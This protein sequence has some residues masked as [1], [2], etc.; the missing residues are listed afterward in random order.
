ME[1]LRVKVGY[2]PLNKSAAVKNPDN[3]RAMS[4]NTE[5]RNINAYFIIWGEPDDY[6]TV[7]LKGS[8]T[9]SINERGPKSKASQKIV[10]LWCH[11]QRELI[12]RPW[13]IVE[14]DIGLR[15]QFKP[16]DV[17]RGN[18]C[19]IQVR[20]GSLDQFSAGFNYVWDKTEYDET[21]DAI[22]V[23]ECMGLELSPVALA[24]QALTHAVRSIGED[25][26]EQTELLLKK[27]PKER[28]LELRGLLSQYASLAQPVGSTDK[29]IQT[30]KQKRVDY[31]YLLKN[32]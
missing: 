31:A 18:Q 12:S 24:S 4:D 10:N 14:D 20:S 26:Y 22:I 32:F 27:I 2:N 28:Q 7:F 9:K 16:D 23:S 19:V 21:E 11:D 29:P 5:D 8:W 15:G 1:Q 13:E 30:R 6:G 25:L 17:P 3:V